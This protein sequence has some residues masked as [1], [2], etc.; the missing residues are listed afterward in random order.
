MGRTANAAP[1][2]TGADLQR[3]LQAVI[4]LTW[5]DNPLRESLDS[6]SQA[7]EV[8]ILLDRNVVPD[9]RIQMLDRGLTLS[10][11]LDRLADANGLAFS[12]VGPVLYMASPD[13]AGA[14]S[15]LAE[16][17]REEARQFPPAVSARLLQRKPCGWEMLAEPRTLVAEAA[18]EH[19]VRVEGLERI[20]HDLWPAAD[21]PPLDLAERLTLLLAGFR[22]SF[23]WAADGTSITLKSVDYSAKVQRTYEGASAAAAA[24][25]TRR[26]PTVDIQRTSQGLRV[27]GDF[28]EQLAVERFLRNGPA[29]RKPAPRV[30]AG[31]KTLYTLRVENKPARAVAASVAES[32]AW[33]LSVNG[34][35]AAALGRLISLDVKDATLEELMAKTL[36][37]LGL[38]W[39]AEDGKLEIFAKQ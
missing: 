31:A 35:A 29:E 24:A 5:P 28:A 14:A 34:A 30:V 22:L 1:W 18:R 38:A 25:L 10:Q 12:S 8:A 2:K 19:G 3:Q 17:R 27:E 20:P 11:M 16:L 23:A 9:R 13:I 26:F 37:P 21:L 36:D 7:Q 15:S 4:G 32:R 6:L 33:E 39:R